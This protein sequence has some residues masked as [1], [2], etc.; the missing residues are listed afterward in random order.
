MSSNP[1]LPKADGTIAHGIKWGDGYV[2]QATS[3]GPGVGTYV[4]HP[5]KGPPRRVI[6][7]DG[8]AKLSGSTL[9]VTPN[10]APKGETFNLV[11]EF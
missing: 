5:Y 6:S 7:G 3:G 8:T 2:V 9:L 4:R 11:V 1:P 10:Q